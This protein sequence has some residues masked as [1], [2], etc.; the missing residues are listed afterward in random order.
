MEAGTAGGHAQRP[1]WHWAAT[2]SVFHIAR[3]SNREQA[4]KRSR[5]TEKNNR[6]YSPTWVWGRGCPR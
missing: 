5:Q 2:V 1:T 3:A 4:K 6:M